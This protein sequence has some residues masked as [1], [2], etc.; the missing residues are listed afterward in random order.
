[1]R[2]GEQ[3]QQEL[4]AICLRKAAAAAAASE[5]GPGAG[6]RVCGGGGAGVEGVREA[7]AC[8]RA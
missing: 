2:A 6:Q 3:V 1:M 5:A 7:V 4:E 8:G